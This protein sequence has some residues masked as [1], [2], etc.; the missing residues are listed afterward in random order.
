[1]ARSCDEMTELLQS[2]VEEPGHAAT[3]GAHGRRTINERHTCRHRA[4]ELLG[5]V[6]ELRGEPVPVAASA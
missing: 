2:M 5:I 4:E 1:M 3:L 6:S